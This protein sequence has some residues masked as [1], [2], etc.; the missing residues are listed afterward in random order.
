MLQIQYRL[1]THIEEQIEDA[2]V[3]QETVA[4]TEHL[5]VFFVFGGTEVRGCGNAGVRDIQQLA[6][7]LYDTG[8][9]VN[10]KFGQ[11]FGKEGTQVVLIVHEERTVAVGCLQG[12]PVLSLPVA[13]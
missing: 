11:L 7:L 8:I 9:E 3:G 2:E 5:V 13:V 12:V 4:F 6:H 10:E 1:V